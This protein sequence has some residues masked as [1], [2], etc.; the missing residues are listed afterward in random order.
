M[1]STNPASSEVAT[2]AAPPTAMIK[3]A[4]PTNGPR[5][6]A[7]SD[8]APVAPF[9]AFPSTVST[10]SVSAAVFSALISLVA[11]RPIK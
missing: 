6:A 9:K 8:A 5:A 4:V 2:V 11:R 7:K 10:P 3:P 1:V